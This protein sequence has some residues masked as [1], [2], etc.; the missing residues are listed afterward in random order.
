M[1]YKRIYDSIIERANLENRKRYKTT[2]S[3]YV[4]YEKHHIIPECFYINRKRK[5]TTGWL[6][7]NPD[8]KE[9][10]VLLTPEE[11]YVVHQLLSKIYPTVNGLVYAL[12]KMSGKHF[13]R[14]NKLYGWIKR[15]SNRLQSEFKKNKPWND[16]RRK[17]LQD[18]P[19]IMSSESNLARKNKMAGRKTSTGT[20]GR[21]INSK[22]SIYVWMLS[23]EKESVLFG[24]MAYSCRINGLNRTHVEKV[25]DGKWSQSKRW[26]YIRMASSDEKLE[27]ISFLKSQGI[28]A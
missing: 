10:L 18:N 14:N 25:C 4:Y 19:V 1:D 21:I 13:G 23:P 24:P 2:H 22:T 28:M 8:S 11:H 3:D 26:T 27:R 9:N 16:K 6:E 7:G 15:K 17:S 12:V 5:G 20:F